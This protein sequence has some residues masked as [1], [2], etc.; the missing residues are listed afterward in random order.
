MS[1]QLLALQRGKHEPS[2]NWLEKLSLLLRLLHCG[3]SDIR[4]PNRNEG[5]P[6]ELYNHFFLNI[7][8]IL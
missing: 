1:L 3:L 8:F 7:K 2:K 5:I 4:I 6:A